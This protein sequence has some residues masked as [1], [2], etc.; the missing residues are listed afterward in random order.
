M[1]Y[2]RGNISSST[3][4]RLLEMARSW[5]LSWDD[6]ARARSGIEGAGI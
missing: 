4:H 6:M 1:M 3:Y 2:A 5:D